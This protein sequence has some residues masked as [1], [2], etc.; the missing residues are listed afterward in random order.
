[1]SA[2][3]EAFQTFIRSMKIGFEEWHDG[4]SYNLQ[5]LAALPPEEL[6]EV[7]ALLIGRRDEDWRDTEALASIASSRAIAALVQSL[8]APNRAVR[9]AA[10]AHLKSIDALPDID[11][12]LIEALEH[13]GFGDG[14]A[15]ALR[16]AEQYPTAAV[17]R[18]LLRGCLSAE[19]GKAV[20]FAALSCFLHGKSR[21]AFDMAQR[22]FFLRFN[23]DDPRARQQVFD[24]MCASIGVY[25]GPAAR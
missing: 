18:C 4:L 20:H 10:A 11:A 5:A 22:P 25:G 19:G 13:G 21:E 1:M 14:L 17:K 23:T 8:D 12:V 2:K 7:E 3:S 9:L 24:E 15:E 16:L 6:A